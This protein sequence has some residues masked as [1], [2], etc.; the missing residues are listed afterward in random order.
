MDDQYVTLAADLTGQMRLRARPRPGLVAR[1]REARR[2]KAWQGSVG[3]RA[4]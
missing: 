1:S 4:V 3:A 2:V